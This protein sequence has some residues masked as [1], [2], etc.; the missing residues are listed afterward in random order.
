MSRIKGCSAIVQIEDPSNL[1][2]FVDIG[3]G[4]SWTLD[5]SMETS[6]YKWLGTD[7]EQT[8][9][10]TKTFSFSFDLDYDPKEVGQKLITHAKHK[11]R[12]FPTDDHDDATGAY[13]EGA[14]V[15]G[16]ISRTGSSDGDSVTASVS[17]DGSG[18]L[19]MEGAW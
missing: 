15:V 13:F 18:A 8:D 4:T 9:G 19:T 14:A 6:K 5:T 3:Q 1:G 12:L 7:E 10:T 11:F 16:S 2:A 17:A